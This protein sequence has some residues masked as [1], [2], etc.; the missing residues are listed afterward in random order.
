MSYSLEIVFNNRT[1]L[2]LTTADSSSSSMNSS[3]SDLTDFMQSES[4]VEDNEEY[5]NALGTRPPI[6]FDFTS[7]DEFMPVIA[8]FHRCTEEDPTNRPSASTI[9]AALQPI[10]EQRGL[11]I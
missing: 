11:T 3:S 10:I 9:V 4:L 7:K 5:L 2:S 1:S 8:L 6:P